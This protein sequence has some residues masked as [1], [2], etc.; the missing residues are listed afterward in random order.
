MLL[1]VKLLSVFFSLGQILLYYNS[2]E[3]KVN[4]LTESRLETVP[5]DM[6][7]D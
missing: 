7:S 1:A 3:I 6:A 5:L 2:T 4:K